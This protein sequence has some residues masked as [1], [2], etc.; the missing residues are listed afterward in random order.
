MHLIQ[1]KKM[2]ALSYDPLIRLVLINQFKLNQLFTRY[3][4]RARSS[5]WCVEVCVEHAP[6]ALSPDK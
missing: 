3:Q 6:T 4:V 2:L 5:M 1:P